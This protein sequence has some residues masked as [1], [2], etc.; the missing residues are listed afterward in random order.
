MT[1]IARE[2]R[3]KSQPRMIVWC[4]FCKRSAVHTELMPFGGHYY[5]CSACCRKNFELITKKRPLA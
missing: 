5:Q 1:S 4:Y 3:S 2:L